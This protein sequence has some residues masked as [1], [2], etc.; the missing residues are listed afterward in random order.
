MLSRG[1]SEEALPSTHLDPYGFKMI[2]GV[3]SF[4]GDLQ[5][6]AFQHPM[7]CKKKNLIWEK[8]SLHW[9]GTKVYHDGRHSHWEEW[10]W[11]ESKKLVSY[12]QIYDTGQQ[13]AWLR[14]L[15]LK[16]FGR[17]GTYNFSNGLRRFFPQHTWI[18]VDSRRTLMRGL[19]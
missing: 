3:R 2:I 11:M 16:E 5:G 14:W 8:G 9:K 18:L 13:E 10:E 17:H 6:V 15:L 4:L 7:E 1:S 19:L 12:L